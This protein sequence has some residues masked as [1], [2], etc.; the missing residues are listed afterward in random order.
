MKSKILFMETVKGLIAPAYIHKTPLF[1][2]ISS[3]CNLYLFCLQYIFQSTKG[4]GVND[5][6]REEWR[7]EIQINGSSIPVSWWVRGGHQLNNESA[8][9]PCVKGGQ[10]HAGLHWE[11]YCQQ[12]KEDSRSPLLWSAGSS[13]GLISV[14][15]TKH[16][17]MTLEEGYKDDGEKHL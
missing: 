11:G 12:V 15:E 4:R 13:S 5:F 6:N 3:L 14:K 10:Q 7:N 2:K 16:T 9:Y 1:L 8:M 17:R